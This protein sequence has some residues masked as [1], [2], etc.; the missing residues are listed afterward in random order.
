MK[1]T[2]PY[3]YKYILDEAKKMEDNIKTNNLDIE[4]L[5]EN[6][7]K[8]VNCTYMAGDINAYLG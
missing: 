8:E 6:D 5:F 7:S 1:E 2:L 3:I 4:N